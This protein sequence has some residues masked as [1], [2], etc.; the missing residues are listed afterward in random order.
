MRQLYD[1]LAELLPDPAFLFLNYGFADSSG[2]NGWIRE[3][4][5]RY[6]YHLSLARHVLRGAEPAGKRVLE[7][8][9]GRGGN[10]YYLATYA[11]AHQ[12]FGLE[13]SA[14][15]LRLC[16]QSGRCSNVRFVRGEAESLPFQ[17]EAFDLVLNLESAHC[18]RD[19]GRF[20]LQTR[21]VLRPGGV[22]CFADLWGWDLFDCDWQARERALAGGLFEITSSEDIGGQV[23]QALQ[24]DTGLLATIGG[25]A[26]PSNEHLVERILGGTEALRQCLAEGR[27]SYR[28]WRLR[29]PECETRS[30]GLARGHFAQPD[31]FV[32]FLLDIAKDPDR[33]A[34][35]EIDPDAELEATA[36]SPEEKA[37]IKSRDSEQVRKLLH[38]PPQDELPLLL[39]ALLE[40]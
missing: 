3:E 24:D 18:Y 33:L 40:F 4:D 12:V 17:A 25:M 8:G 38:S 14:G 6:R 19:F 2:D 34:R 31:A 20:L 5:R 29:K 10:C 11:G 15:N 13:P 23:L 35:L 7:V 36:L 16:A 22:F 37:A 9:S 26:T 32:Q 1:T 28:V 21:R 30:Q 27:C 39:A